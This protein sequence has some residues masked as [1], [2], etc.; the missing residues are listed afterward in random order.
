M[1]GCLPHN[2]YLIQC[3][4]YYLVILTSAAIAGMGVYLLT[5]IIENSLGICLKRPPANRYLKSTNTCTFITE[6]YRP[7]V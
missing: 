3:V 1:T 2:S 4:P 7:E 5:C 6:K